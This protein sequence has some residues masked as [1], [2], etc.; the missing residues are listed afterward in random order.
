MH[1]DWRDMSQP[2]LV[3][4][5][6]SSNMP[7]IFHRIQ[8]TRPSQARPVIPWSRRGNHMKRARNVPDKRFWGILCRRNRIIFN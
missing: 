5:I 4:G 6:S 3:T 8:N 2:H 7:F 1:S